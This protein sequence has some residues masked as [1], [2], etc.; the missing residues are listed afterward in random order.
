MQDR[1]HEKV[2]LV[3]TTIRIPVDVKDALA[4]AAIKE[5]RSSSNLLST[6]AREWLTQQGYLPA[7]S[8]SKRKG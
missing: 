2:E 4:V 1:A 5:N 8:G 6:I 7:K 3:M